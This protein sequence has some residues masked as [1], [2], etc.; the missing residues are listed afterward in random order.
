MRLGT[1]IA[2]VA[3]GG[4]LAAPPCHAV[5]CGDIITDSQTL[6]GDLNCMTNPGLTIGDGGKLDMDGFKLTC[7]GT[8]AGIA[9]SAPGA[10]LSNGVVTG[11]TG[12]GVTGAAGKHKVERVLVS[13]SSTGFSLSGGG[14][15]IKSCAALNNTVGFTVYGD[16]NALTQIVAS[17]NT[18][19][20]V[21]IGG[22]GNK[23][24]DA[25]IVGAGMA[26]G[27][28]AG[29]N[30]NKVSKV[31]ISRCTTGL[32]I[33]GSFNKISEV[34]SLKHTVRG[35]D[36]SGNT[37]QIK[38]CVAGGGMG[39]P[40]GFYLGGGTDNSISG[41]RSMGSDYGIYFVGA[42]N[43]ISKNKVF[44]SVQNGI[45]VS[46]NDNI[47]KSNLAVG[48]GMTDLFE[49]VAGCVN[50]DVWSNN[51]GTRNDACIE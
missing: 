44:G 46:G 45:Y 15:K 20:G 41:C 42:R 2:L 31:R 38:K 6:T 50:S 7:V 33:N 51:I 18:S 35:F 24:S 9:L 17:G 26:T 14:N 3:L 13:G 43:V 23:I 11:C 27:L 34:T 25:S 40:T 10:K 47:I 4:L 5:V 21:S 32:V 39:A 16:G 19:I 49:T 37:N 29:G 36:I 48:S 8:I 30:Q 12:A 1:R 22:V 28:L